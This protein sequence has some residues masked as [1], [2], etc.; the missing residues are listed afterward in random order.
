[1]AE[2]RTIERVQSAL[3]KVAQR[4]NRWELAGAKLFPETRRFMHGF[5]EAYHDMNGE[6]ALFPVDGSRA[7]AE[8][9]WADRSDPGWG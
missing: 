1:M 3:E 8:G 4:L 7:S 2:R 9:E 5:A 6:R